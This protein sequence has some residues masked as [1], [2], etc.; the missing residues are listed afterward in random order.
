MMEQLENLKRKA[1]ESKNGGFFRSFTEYT[2]FNPDSLKEFDLYVKNVLWGLMKSHIN[3]EVSDLNEGLKAERQN[4]KKLHV[5]TDFRDPKALYS[6][7]FYQPKIG[8]I[9]KT[10]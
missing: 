7:D 3:H 6:L 10:Q 5:R 1:H 4:L 2:H 8:E 9:Q